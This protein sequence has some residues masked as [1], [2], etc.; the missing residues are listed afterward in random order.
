MSRTIGPSIAKSRSTKFI[1]SPAPKYSS[2][3]LRPPTIAM[4]LIRDPA[5]VV[6]AA[7]DAAE[8]ERALARLAEACPCAS[9]TD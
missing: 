4:R 7:I 2:P 6:H 3:M 9:R 5:L 8:V 1:S